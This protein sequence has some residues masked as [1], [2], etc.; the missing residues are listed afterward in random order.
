MKVREPVSTFTNIAYGA[1]GAGGWYI[2][3][4]PE[5]VLFAASFA[6]LM[7]MS[8][9]YHWS[10]TKE[11]QNADELGIYIA[12]TVIFV[13]C[14][15]ISF[16]AQ[17][18]TAVV[19]YLLGGLVVA[20]LDSH[21]AAPVL[22]I[23]ICIVA[24]GDWMWSALLFAGFLGGAV[25]KQVATYYQQ[26]RKPRHHDVFHGLWHL[27]TAAWSLVAWAAAQGILPSLTEVI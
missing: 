10:L 23:A 13:A 25:L 27:V 2:Q 14:L 3:P 17:V 12:Y 4:G 20:V 7:F 18:I 11:G 8:A 22:V 26:E 21:I 19:I 6:F 16:A 15:P 5:G 24:P 1:V 9:W